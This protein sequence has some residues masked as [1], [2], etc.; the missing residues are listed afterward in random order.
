MEKCKGLDKCS[1]TYWY[2]NYPGS[3]G[4]TEPSQTTKSTKFRGPTRSSTWA[5][6]STCY[7]PPPGS[8]TTSQKPWPLT[9]QLQLLVET[10]FLKGSPRG[11]VSFATNPAPGHRHVGS[12]YPSAPA[13]EGSVSLRAPGGACAV[14]QLRQNLAAPGLDLARI[15][16][17]AL[18]ASI[19]PHYCAALPFNHPTP[20]PNAF[21]LLMEARKARAT[22]QP[23]P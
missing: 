7:P 14:P 16:S 20:I 17:K 11:H 2:K 15:T 8:R 5:P 10:R 3:F 21:S 6:S 23:K 9:D 18:I 4:Y 1:P 12:A 22:I 13:R 19:R